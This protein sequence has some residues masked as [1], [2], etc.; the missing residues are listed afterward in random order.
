MHS[1]FYVSRFAKTIY[2]LEWREYLPTCGVADMC[3]APIHILIKLSVC[4]EDG[5]YIVICHSI[6]TCKVAIFEHVQ[7]CVYNNS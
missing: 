7:M 5:L 4:H 3:I 6:A 2:N 1:K